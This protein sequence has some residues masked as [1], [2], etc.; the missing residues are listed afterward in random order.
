MLNGNYYVGRMVSI[1]VGTGVSENAGI[2][3][4][5]EIPTLYCGEEYLLDDVGSIHVWLDN[6]NLIE[7]ETI[8]WSVARAGDNGAIGEA[9]IDYVNDDMRGAGIR[10]RN[11]YGIGTEN[12]IVTAASSMGHTFTCEFSI[13]VVETPDYLPT[14][15][16]LNL[17]LEYQVDESLVFNNDCIVFTDGG[18]FSADNNYRVYHNLVSD[19]FRD[20]NHSWWDEDGNYNLHFYFEETYELVVTVAIGKYELT[21]KYIITVG[22]GL[23]DDVHIS[24]NQPTDIY[25]ADGEDAWVAYFEVMNCRFFSEEMVEWQIE[26]VE[27]SENIPAELY[28][29]N[30]QGEHNE[31]ANIHVTGSNGECGWVRYR[32]TANTALYSV[33]NDI[34]LNFEERPEDLPTGIGVECDEYRFEVGDTFGFYNNS[35]FE[36]GCVSEN[37]YVSDEIWFSN[38]AFSGE[39]LIWNEDGTGFDVTF[40]RDG[41]H[42]FTVVKWLNN[43]CYTHDIVVI[44]GSGMNEDSELVIDQRFISC[45]NEAG[46]NDH[47]VADAFVNGYEIANDEELGWSLELTDVQSESGNAP[48]ELYINEIFNNGLNANIFMTGVTGET[49]SVTYTLTAVSASGILFTGE[50]TYNVIELTDEYPTEISG[51]DTEVYLNVGDTYTFDTSAVTLDKAVPEGVEAYVEYFDGLDYLEFLPGFQWLE[52]ESFSVTFMRDAEF[53][54]RVA[55]RIGTN[56]W[57]DK[58]VHITVGEGIAEEPVLNMNSMADVLF[59]D[60]PIGSS[61]IMCELY[62]G[63]YTPYEGECMFWEIEHID[64]EGFSELYFSEIRDNDCTAQLS[65]SLQQNETGTDTYRIH[66]TTESGFRTSVD[67][68]VST[69]W[70]YDSMP[71]DIWIDNFSIPVDQEFVFNPEDYVNMNGAIDENAKYYYEVKVDGVLEAEEG[72]EYIFNGDGAMI[73]SFR[74][75]PACENRYQITVTLWIGNYFSRCSFTLNVGDGIADNVELYADQVTY[76]VYPGYTENE[77]AIFAGLNNYNMMDWECLNWYLERVDDNEGEPCSLYLESEA[78]W[79]NVKYC[80]I[81]G[82][83]QAEYR[84]VVETDS[85]FTDSIEFTIAAEEL[86]EDAPTDLVIN[87]PEH[88]EIGETLE[89][90]YA[91]SVLFADGTVYEDSGVRT[92]VPDLENQPVWYENDSVYTDEGFNITFTRDGRYKFEVVMMMGNYS[93]SRNVNITVGTGVSED[94]HIGMNI[95]SFT[96]ITNQGDSWIGDFYLHNYTLLDGETVEWEITPITENGYEDVAHLYLDNEW[97]DGRG[98]DLSSGWTDGEECDA[99]YRVTARTSGGFQTETEFHIEVRDISGMADGLD[100]IDYIDINVGEDFYFDAWNYVNPNGYVPGETGHYYRVIVDQRLMDMDFEMYD[101]A[102]FR[103]NPSADGRY[104]LDV[105]CHMGNYTIYKP[106]VIRVGSGISEDLFV[107]WQHQIDTVYTDGERDIWLGWGVIYNYATIDGCELDWQFERVDE[108]GGNPVELYCENNGV[109]CNVYLG[110]I[111]EPGTVTYRLTVYTPEGWSQSYDYT[112]TVAETPEN[113]PTALDIETEVYLNVG[114]VYTYREENV[115]FADGEV[116]E[117]ASVRTSVPGFDE[118]PA[119]NENYVEWHEDGNGFD[120]HF[121]HNGR[122]EFTVCKQVGNHRVYA[123]V[124]IYVGTGL[125]EDAYADYEHRVFDVYEYGGTDAYIGIAYMRNYQLFEGEESVWSWTRVDDECTCNGELYFSDLG[126]CVEVYAANLDGCGTGVIRYDL[127]ADF[128][129][130]N[131]HTFNIQVNVVDMPEGLPTALAMPEE[132]MV[133][134]VG[135]WTDISYQDFCFA[136]GYEPEGAFVRN[137]LTNIEGSDLM[138]NNYV[139]YNV[140]NLHIDFHTPGEYVVDVTRTINNYAVAG[141]FTI[142]VNE[143]ETF[144]NASQPYTT[145]YADVSETGCE[146]NWVAQVYLENIELGEGDSI[147]W[148][149]E[150]IGLTEGD[151]PVIDIYVDNT[152]D[153]NRGANIHYNSLNGLGESDWRVTAAVG[154]NTWSADLHFSVVELPENLPTWIESP[155]EICIQP[156]ELSTFYRDSIMPGDGEIPDG[157]DVTYDIWLNDEICSQPNF[158]WLDDDRNFCVSFGSEGR[159]P[160]EVSLRIGNYRI[161]KTIYFTVGD[162][163]SDDVYFDYMEASNTFYLG[164]GDLWVADMY[165]GNYEPVYDYEIEWELQFMGSD[166]DSSVELYIGDRWD[167]SRWANIHARQISDNPGTVYYS[168]VVR[169]NG[170]EVA[171]RDITISVEELPEDMPTA[172]N[173]GDVPTDVYL[174]VGDSYYFSTEGI[175]FADGNVPENALTFYDAWGM[176]Q[177]IDSQDDFRF[178]YFNCGIDGFEMSVTFNNPGRYHFHV[179]KCIGNHY[180]SEEI[181]ITV[182]EIDME[183]VRLVKEVPSEIWLTDSG[184]S[185]FGWWALENYLIFSSDD[186][187]WKLERITD[188]NSP[189]QPVAELI[190]ADWWENRD[191]VNLHINDTGSETGSETYRISIWLN[192]EEIAADEFTVTV[193]ERPEDL[194]NDISIDSEIFVELGESYTLTRDQLSPADGNVPEG[195]EPYWELQGVEN[196]PNVSWHEDGFGFTAEFHDDGTYEFA[197]AMRIGGHYV[198]KVV[199]IIAGSGINPDTFVEWNADNGNTFY[200]IEGID[201]GIGAADLTNY[202]LRAGDSINWNVEVLEGS[203]LCTVYIPDSVTNESYHADL[204][205]TDF[206]GETGTLRYK[207]SVSTDAGFCDEWEFAYNV[208]ETPADLPTELAYGPFSREV[209]VGEPLEFNVSQIGFGEGYVDENAWIYQYVELGDIRHEWDDEG[210]VVTMYFDEPGEYTFTAGANINNYKISEEVTITVY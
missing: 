129:G 191:G 154:E 19:Y 143:P 62:L 120:F 135:D 6:Y 194:P 30:T 24:F 64:G 115:N 180:V 65:A 50:I 178:E 195:I 79:C 28:I 182:G 140:D 98:I 128:G 110:E 49:G 71:G 112:V 158:K 104:W 207:L 29:N 70:N 11:I 82:A 9:Y 121:D 16:E 102:R 38:S 73:D 113:L 153:D 159:Y 91:E 156:N 199:H 210:R 155:D 14:G 22:D 21:N 40:T 106:I 108:N 42:V 1:I 32:V 116:P 179:V 111:Y 12:F 58:E 148:S 96:L 66:I 160:F 139:D 162:G 94:A 137:W 67:Y 89:F 46:N 105:Y 97:E 99:A 175:D 86:P 196:L 170:Q 52:N 25:Y 163:I 188:E 75:T 83:G 134:T 36:D 161:T 13:N 123:N 31:A 130:E 92:L 149:L 69:I 198:E 27:G 17:P 59:A 33:S 166:G 187:E 74:F 60:A 206:T 189:E 146:D 3:I 93:V 54:F 203:N 124:H 144:V 76:V 177:G 125:D 197:V 174:N 173:M 61:A 90:S 20:G 136:D 41:R 57:L 26:Y 208:V 109:Q 78:N 101:D 169:I 209:A 72:F 55:Y 63:N 190:L 165:L 205:F 15:F 142:I 168:L 84:L 34:W 95:P 81:T 200:A 172:L 18:D 51:F 204:N 77:T 138:N 150:P 23:K 192:S 44:V 167:M 4:S 176:D 141:Q 171:F 114:D 43:I 85:G 164:N 7:G 2:G 10:V 184:Y 39:E 119:A 68:T 183:N 103:V 56:Y 127:T 118:L 185:W 88:F 47:F 152:W 145:I 5:N 151:S 37:A 53:T 131:V 35:W 181:R 122:Y 80:G 117:G 45:F 157:A 193:I 107:D 100:G 126:E 133:F 8:E 132:P 202:Y 87:I 147:E 186:V 48:V 201:H